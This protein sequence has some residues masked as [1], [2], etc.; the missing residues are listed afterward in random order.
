MVFNLYGALIPNNKVNI[1]SN[2]ITGNMKVSTI[3]SRFPNTLPIFIEN[4]FK[5]LSNPITR[6]TFAKVISLEK[7][8]EKHDVSFIPFLE[9]LNQSIHA[10]NTS[11][12]LRTSNSK[13]NVGKKIKWG[14][15]CDKSVT[16][17]SLIKT[18]VDTKLVFEKYYG[19]DCFSCPGYAI[20][21]IEQ[22]AQMHNV[23]L[24]FILKEVNRVID[25]D[26]SK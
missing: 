5:S 9:K 16:V 24:N 8:C 7:A 15:H 11:L 18:Y 17:G 12:S 1:I 3:I 14:E 10:Q 6:E 23:S 21:T 22:T 19:K 4:G 20:E 13:I 25:T 2:K 26:L